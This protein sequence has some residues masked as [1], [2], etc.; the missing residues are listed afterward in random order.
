MMNPP[1]RSFLAA[2]F[3]V[4]SIVLQADTLDLLLPKPVKGERLAGS[5]TAEVCANVKVVKGAVPGAPS[6]V[7]AE[8]YVLEVSKTGVTVTGPRSAGA[9]S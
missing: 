4:T 8:A 3:A 5:A 2:I 7:A 6:S 1:F 9:G